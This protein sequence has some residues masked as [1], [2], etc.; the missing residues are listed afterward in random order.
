MGST[1]GGL[2]DTWPAAGERPADLQSPGRRRE[3]LPGPGSPT[4]PLGKHRPE[5]PVSC[6]QVLWGQDVS[7][8]GR[9]DQPPPR[10]GLTLTWAPPVCS[11]ASCS[12][13]GA[14][15]FLNAP[16]AELWFIPQIGSLLQASGQIHRELT[17]FR[18]RL[19]GRK[20]HYLNGPM[21]R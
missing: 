19:T 11:L 9:A 2:G 4:S 18:P 5:L 21:G 14:L 17:S 3:P 16:E 6:G 13:N 10:E 15:H 7:T 1:R 12:R 8:R 20:C